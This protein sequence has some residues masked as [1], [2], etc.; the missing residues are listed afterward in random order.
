MPAN[1]AA[2][3]ATELLGTIDQFSAALNNAA[4]QAA[5][6]LSAAQFAD[7]A[8]TRDELRAALDARVAAEAGFRAAVE[9]AQQAQA[10][11]TEKL[12]LLSRS[13]N[14]YVSM[15]NA[16]REQAGLSVRASVSAP[17]TLPLIADLAAT[18]RT[19]GDTALA[20]SGPTRGGLQY[21]I[22]GRAQNE[23]AWTL[24]GAVTRTAFMHRGAGIGLQRHYKIVP[25]RGERQGTPSNEATVYA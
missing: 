10:R 6:G 1:R 17:A 18:P 4:G 24:L 3:S 15:T 14:N 11:A 19:S 8:A 2:R 9:T 13:A 12:R 23:A 16:Y 21:L 20:W 22:Y 5:S 7:L 25:Q